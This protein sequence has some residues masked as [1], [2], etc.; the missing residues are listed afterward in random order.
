MIPTIRRI[1]NSSLLRFFRETQRGFFGGYDHGTFWKHIKTV[2]P[3]Q[4]PT[5]VHVGLQLKK[6]TWTLKMVF[7]NRNLLFQG[8]MFR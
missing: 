1:C 4:Y 2:C 3:I 8:S 6:Q 7:S 5:I